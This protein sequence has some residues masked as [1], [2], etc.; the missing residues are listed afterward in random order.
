V[1]VEGVSSDKVPVKSGV[2]QGS[3]FGPSLF[4]Y[5]VNDMPEGLASS[6]RLYADDTIAYLA[7]TLDADANVLQDDLNKL[8]EWEG[9]CY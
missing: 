4:L 2:P 5:H 8:A 3:V 1:V 6:V 9:A 7:T